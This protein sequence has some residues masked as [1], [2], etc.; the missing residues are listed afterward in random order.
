MIWCRSRT[1][2]YVRIIVGDGRRGWKRKIVLGDCLDGEGGLIGGSSTGRLENTNSPR[3]SN[4][5]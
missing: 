1:T 2:C 5:E 4:D 3:L